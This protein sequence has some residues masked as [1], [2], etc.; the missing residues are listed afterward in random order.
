MASKKN[1]TE[2]IKQVEKATAKSKKVAKAAE[3]KSAEKVA[4]KTANEKVA[5]TETKAAKTAKTRS[6]KSAKITPV[7]PELVPP[8]KVPVKETEEVKV[9]AVEKKKSVLF[10]ASEGL[11]FIKTGGLA[12]VIGSLP[13]AI[14][15]KG[16]YDVRV[17]MPLYSGIDAGMRNNFAFI[18]NFNVGLAWRN[19]YCGL[20]SCRLDG[21]IFYFIALPFISIFINL[22]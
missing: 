22:K 18:T 1:V 15:A 2:E 12:D 17:I 4:V 21:V 6:A 14:A 3:E 20:F 11:P 10:V 7:H 8:I 5:K 19:Q 9:V 16:E 13:K